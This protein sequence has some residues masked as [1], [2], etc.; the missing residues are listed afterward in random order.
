MMSNNNDTKWEV[1]DEIIS[2]YFKM[3]EEIKTVKMYEK[4]S[5]LVE[6]ESILLLDEVK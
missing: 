3:R 6:A 5:K 1:M 2:E 4:K